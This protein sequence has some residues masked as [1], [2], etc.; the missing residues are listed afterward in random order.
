MNL[1]EI[2]ARETRSFFEWSRTN[3]VSPSAKLLW[4]TLMS[5]ADRAALINNEWSE[6]FTLSITKLSAETGYSK[7]TIY[8]AREQL[9]ELGRIT[10]EKGQG[11]KAAVYHIC[12]F[13]PELVSEKST[14]NPTQT[15]T[16]EIVSGSVSEIVSEIPTQN[17]TLTTTQTSTQSPTPPSIYKYNNNL[18]NYTSKLASLPRAREDEYADEVKKVREWYEQCTKHQAS[19]IPSFDVPFFLRQGVDI[20]LILRA[21]EKAATRK[22]DK[23]WQYAMA[24]LRG[25]IADGVLTLEQ[26]MQHSQS[27][28][29]PLKP[30]ESGHKAALGQFENSSI[31][32]NE[33]EQLIAQG[34]GGY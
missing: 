32:M 29:M 8:A 13:T 5:I 9:M 28:N 1:M 11:S 16:E 19:D 12:L 23:P 30:H 31:D 10:Y 15:S 2:T 27:P 7:D 22:A 6:Y 4:H 26:F 17:P 24:V 34:K 18:I 14:Q 21:I 25:C 3:E 33:L 20:G